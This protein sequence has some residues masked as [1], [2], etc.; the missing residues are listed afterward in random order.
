MA[1]L[2][3]ATFTELLNCDADFYRLAPLALKPRMVPLMRQMVPESFV[4]TLEHDDALLAALLAHPMFARDPQCQWNLLLNNATHAKSAALI[5]ARM[6]DIGANSEYFCE[7]M[8]RSSAPIVLIKKI[9]LL[10]RDHIDWTAQNHSTYTLLDRISQEGDK[11]FLLHL[12]AR[13]A[14]LGTNTPQLTRDA[15]HAGWRLAL[16]RARDESTTG[17]AAAG[18]Q[19]SDSHGSNIF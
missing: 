1:H 12:Y 3:T 15:A 19:A 10:L 18:R 14:R 5:L 7:R 11:L 16:L 8:A 17:A 6:P 13:G 2:P 4:A 9:Y